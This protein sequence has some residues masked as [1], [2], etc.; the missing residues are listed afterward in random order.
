MEHEKHPKRVIIEAELRQA[1]HED[2]YTMQDGEKKRHVAMPFFIKNAEGRMECQN[3][4][5]H[6]DLWNLAELI[7]EGRVYVFNQETL[8]HEAAGTVIRE[9]GDLKDVA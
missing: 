2:F 6:S 5:L 7:S 4:R 8:D 3:M 1:T 9:I